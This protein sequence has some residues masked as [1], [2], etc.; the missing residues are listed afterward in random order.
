[1]YVAVSLGDVALSIKPAV[2]AEKFV[3]GQLYCGSIN[4]GISTRRIPAYRNGNDNIGMAAS[5][6]GS[7]AI[8]GGYQ[9]QRSVM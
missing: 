2:S 5:V 3:S 1:M 9:P 7:A 4:D 8:C 6:N